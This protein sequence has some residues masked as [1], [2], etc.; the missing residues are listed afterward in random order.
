MSGKKNHFNKN[1]R[2]HN[3]NTKN[4]GIILSDELKY[5]LSENRVLKPFD[6]IELQSFTIESSSEAVSDEFIR[7]ALVNG[8][9]FHLEEKM[10][11]IVYFMGHCVLISDFDLSTFDENSADSLK[12]TLG[13][14]FSS[15]N[16]GE[17]SNLHAIVMLDKHESTNLEEFHMDQNKYMD[18]LLMHNAVVEKRFN[19]FAQLI[20]GFKEKYEAA[21]LADILNFVSYSKFASVR[22]FTLLM[23]ACWFGAV[24]AIILL[25]EGG[26]KPD[27]ASSSRHRMSALHFVL[28]GPD[29]SEETQLKICDLLV[30]RDSSI[31]DKACHGFY[32]IHRA[33]WIPSQALYDFF[34]A[35]GADANSLNK[36][37]ET[38]AA[39]LATKLN[40]QDSSSAAVAPVA[41]P[42]NNEKKYV[43]VKKE[44]PVKSAKIAQKSNFAV[45]DDEDN[46]SSDDE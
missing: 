2:N 5:V 6:Y 43:F 3:Q 37:K 45:L 20:A 8:I 1:N 26:A 39:L 15:L 46:E 17:G 42:K 41:P 7:T 4:K 21:E 28:T 40:P 19:D 10:Q 29:L 30:E 44:Q 31:V 9:R 13:N 18:W 23:L 38:A 16:Q 12:F 14:S 35:K 27:A 11:F 33:A 34:I 25:L 22:R 24:D 32:P 36:Y